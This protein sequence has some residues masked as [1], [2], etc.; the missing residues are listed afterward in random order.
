[1]LYSLP[2]FNKTLIVLLTFCEQAGTLDISIEQ[3]CRYGLL[4]V[5]QAKPNS[6]KARWVTSV[7]LQG[8][9]FLFGRHWSLQVLKVINNNVVSCLDDNGKEMVVMGRGL[10]FGVKPGS[11]LNTEMIEKVFRMDSEEEFSRLKE[12]FARLPADLLELCN[13]IIDYA[14]QVLG[15]GMNESIYLT[16][17]D[18]IQ[19]SIDRCRKGLYQHNALNTEVRVFYPEEYAVGKYALEQIRLA[20]KVSLPPDEAASIALHLVNAEYDSSMRVT[21]RAAQVLQPVV[22]IMENWA[23]LHLNKSHLFYDE[24]L[25]HLKFMAMQVFTQDEQCWTENTV[26]AEVTEKNIPEAYHCAQAVTDFLKERSGCDVPTVEIAYLAI[27]IQ[28]ACIK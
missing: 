13:G 14:N 4:L 27:C 8:L 18:H 20:Q 11:R 22:N 9:V 1:M 21:I 2:N 10:G 26:L 23:G 7:I 28:R 24:L 16:L 19:F 6:T 25:V 3:I 12:L 5:M 17:T 15:R